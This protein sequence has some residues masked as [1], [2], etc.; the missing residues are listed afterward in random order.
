[1]IINYVGWIVI[2]FISV[3]FSDLKPRSLRH[4]NRRH[5]LGFRFLMYSL[6]AWGV[7]TLIV[8]VGQILDNVANVPENIIKPDFGV[9]SCWFGGIE[10]VCNII[11]R[12]IFF[13]PYFDK[14]SIFCQNC[15]FV[16][17]KFQYSW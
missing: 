2:V 13:W 15:A 12:A 10:T 8:S 6:Y 1:M 16:R 4:H 5:H 11:I 7:P 17:S 9:Y 14:K 3:D